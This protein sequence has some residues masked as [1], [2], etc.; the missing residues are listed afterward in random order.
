MEGLMTVRR[1]V[2]LAALLIAA[3]GTT[4]VAQAKPQGAPAAKPT[5]MTA[6]DSLVAR[7]KSLYDALAKNDY[8]AFAKAL[9]SDFM[10]VSGDGAVKWEVAKSADM[11]KNCVTGKWTLTNTKVTPAGTDLMVLTYTA[12]G[13]QTCNGQKAPSPINALSVWE[14]KGSAWIPIAHSETPAVT[15]KK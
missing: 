5:G 6:A 8:A 14:H 10:Y 13:D 4:V 15:P 7:E 3:A 2:G 11:L 1:T 9:G 12:T